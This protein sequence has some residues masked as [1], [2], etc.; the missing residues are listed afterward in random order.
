MGMMKG[1]NFVNA[2]GIPGWLLLIWVGGVYY[3]A[4]I[5][6]AMLIAISEFYTMAEKKGATPLRWIGLSTT[7]LI[8][9]YFHV[10]SQLTSHQIIGSIILVILLTLV[11]ELFSKEE[12]PGLN[13]AYTLAGILFVSV[14][15][16]TA[17][18]LRQFD[19]AMN[20]QLTLTMVLS[21]WV[22]DS[23]AFIFGTKYGKAKI[24]PRVSPKKSWVGSISGMIASL[25]L[26]VSFHYQGWLGDYFGLTNVLILGFITGGFGQLGDFTES[27]LKR[28][29]GVKDSGTLLK[30]HGG[31]LDRFDSLIFATPLTYLYVHFLMHF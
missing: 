21:V 1:R 13:I 12:N 3:S 24:F 15:L 6:I 14:L 18:D 19:T 30:G 26:F 29:A 23:A 20:T 27:L 16:G 2:L 9:Y 10:Q 28:D 5:L 17:I 25:V 4:F 7:V 8:A 11:W 31:V 22:C